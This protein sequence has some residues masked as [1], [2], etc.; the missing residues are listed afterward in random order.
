VAYSLGSVAGDQADSVVRGLPV[1]QY[2]NVEH[3][4]FLS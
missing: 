3:L 1:E 2:L 4:K